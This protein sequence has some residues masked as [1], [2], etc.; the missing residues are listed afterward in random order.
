MTWSLI[1]NYTGEHQIYIMYAIIIFREVFRRWIRKSYSFLL[2]WS[3]FGCR[4]HRNLKNGHFRP[5]SAPS[6][7]KSWSD[8]VKWIRFLDSA[9]KNTFQFYFCFLQGLGDFPKIVILWKFWIFSDF[10][11]FFS[12]ISKNQFYWEIFK[13]LYETKKS[14]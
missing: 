11:H 6:A 8:G 14:F 7:A 10:L 13:L 2:I 4:V 1:C 9:S 3:I 5:F 12:K